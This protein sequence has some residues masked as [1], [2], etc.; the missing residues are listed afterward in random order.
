MKAQSDIEF[1]IDV[2]IF[3]ISILAVVSF[4][5]SEMPKVHN[6]YVTNYKMAKCYQISEYLLFK[7]FSSGAPYFINLTKVNEFTSSCNSD[8]AGLVKEL[9]VNGLLIV[10]VENENGDIVS[11]CG[12]VNRLKRSY[13]INRFGVFKNE[14]TGSYE[15]AKIT[16]G[17]Y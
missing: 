12:P 7:N 8:Y 14:T 3:A 9:N 10:R 11:E 13:I 16:V 2:G 4:I 17:V 6:N 5:A 1:I 15:I